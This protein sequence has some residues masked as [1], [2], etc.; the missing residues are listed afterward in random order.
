MRSTS[1]SQKL[2]LICEK[3]PAGF[4]YTTAYIRNPLY[5]HMETACPF[6]K[7]VQTGR[8]SGRKQKETGVDMNDIQ[9]LSF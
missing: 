9:R 8:R 5:T 3:T 2:P 6:L 1:Y 7:A 4:P